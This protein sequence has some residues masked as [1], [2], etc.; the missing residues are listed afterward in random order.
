MLIGN[1]TPDQA[2]RFRQEFLADSNCVLLCDPE[3]LSY[4]AMGMRRNWGS[5]LHPLV[6]LRAL[7]VL[8]QGFRQGAV[9]GDP[10]QNGGVL[11]TDAKGDILYRYL[12]SRAGDH[13]YQV[14]GSGGN[15]VSR[16]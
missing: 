8:L 12:S 11:I 14:P 6:L 2:R 13:P 5:L 7:V 4:R 15:E 9:Q 1:G 3:L 10:F 16:A